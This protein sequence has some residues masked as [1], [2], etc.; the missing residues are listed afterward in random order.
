[1]ENESKKNIYKKFVVSIKWRFFVGEK[2]R[3]IL[4]N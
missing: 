2:N 3:I 4:K 1:M